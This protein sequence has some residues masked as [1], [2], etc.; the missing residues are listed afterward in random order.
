[1]FGIAGCSDVGAR[2]TVNQDAWCALSAE[3]SVGDVAMAVVCDGVGGLTSG[4]LAS[5][6]VVHEFDRW[7]RRDL[8]PLALASVTREGEISL[9]DVA[10]AWGHLLDDLN[11]RIGEY[12]R[13]RGAR[14]GTTFSGLL[15]CQGRFVVGHVGDSRVYR[16]ASGRIERLTNDQT[17]AASAVARGIVSAEDAPLMPHGSALIQSVGTQV[18]LRPE[19]TYGEA[20]AGDLF[21]ACSD[22]F[23]RRLG[24]EGL[25]DA[26]ARVNI[27]SEDD[28][29]AVTERLIE[30]GVADGERDNLTAVCLSVTEARPVAPLGAREGGAG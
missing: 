21:V 18:G 13:R 3:T 2:K 19:F 4:E 26:Y 25:H 12:G 5:S 9:S 14:M 8:A 11:R 16:I 7:F 15:V 30:Q 17:L 1:M 6:T 27:T 23:Y 20:R 28:L 29:L 24:D 10:D 22:G